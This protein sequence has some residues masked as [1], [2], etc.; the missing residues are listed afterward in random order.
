[1]DD[2]EN[3]FQVLASNTQWILVKPAQARTQAIEASPVYISWIDENDMPEDLLAA[4]QQINDKKPDWPGMQLQFES[5]PEP[6]FVVHFKKGWACQT[7]KEYE[8]LLSKT[9]WEIDR[10][11]RS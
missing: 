6:G 10:L 5:E 1:M 11:R 7:P 3:G 2:I 8:N 4:C 9:I